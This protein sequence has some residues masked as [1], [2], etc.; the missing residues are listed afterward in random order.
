MAQTPRG[1]RGPAQS[2]R[3]GVAG[4]ETGSCCLALPTREA[5]ILLE[6]PSQGYSLT[7]PRSVGFC[8]F[9]W[10]FIL[11]LLWLKALLRTDL[12]VP[13]VGVKDIPAEGEA[14]GAGYPRVAL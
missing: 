2:L 9:T 1:T 12:S 3:P 8:L 4:R 14:S 5:E 10:L 7:L 13:R 6:V 11:S